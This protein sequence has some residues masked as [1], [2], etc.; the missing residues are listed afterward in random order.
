M[1]MPVKILV[2]GGTG[3]TGPFVVNGLLDRGYEVAILNRGSHDSSEIPD[4]VERIIAD[5]HFEETLREALQG[6][7]FD[8]IIGSYGR[9]R[10]IAE[11]AGDYT[12]RLISVGGAP[13]YRGG[14][15]PD[16]VFPAGR[17]VPLPE[18]A[19]KVETE[20]EFKF[21]YLVKKAEDAVMAGHAAG[22]YVA[23]HLRYPLVYGPRQ[24]L[25]CE[26]WVVKRI[27]DKR[28][29]ISLPDNGLTV[30]SRG[31]A[32]N[33]A[34]AVLLCVDQPDTAGGKI[35]NCGDTHQL[36]MAQWV[37]V[38]STAMDWEL[39]IVS[40]PAKF[41][42]PARDMMIAAVHSHHL[43]YDTYAMRSELGY[44]DQVPV[45]EALGRTVE[46]YLSNPPD[47]NASTHA[48]MAQQYE[49]E[50]RLAEIVDVAEQKFESLP[51]VEKGF[52]HPYAHPK[53]PGEGKD[54]MGR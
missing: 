2:I 53:K 43:M 28:K 44:E 25:P 49:I 32:E 36:T 26:W 8:Q 29:I 37:Q 42:Q 40:V 5:P 35:Y 23:T 7:S 4:S 45:V 16:M 52:S 21:G 9:L 24:P 18:D 41:S 39:E 47:L 51:I 27:L 46:W 11:L 1:E 20:E 12:D 50:E 17:Q 13:S 22:D 19:P 31:Y 33:M 3:P 30:L 6:R 10:V 14:E 38:I 54:H 34:H 15:H 48:D